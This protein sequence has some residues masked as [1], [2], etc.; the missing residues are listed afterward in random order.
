VVEVSD[1]SGNVI[2]GGFN[3]DKTKRFTVMDNDTQTDPTTSQT[4]YA[5]TYDSDGN[6]TEPLVEGEKYRVR[7]YA[8]KDVSP[9]QDPLEY[10][11]ISA[12]EGLVGVF[13]VGPAE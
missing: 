6:A 12:S 1:A 5:A 13:T 10:K 9:N 11:L 3:P 2:W 4:Y 8:S 7:I